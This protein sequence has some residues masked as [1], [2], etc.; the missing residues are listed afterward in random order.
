MI[1]IL[2]V[3]TPTNRDGYRISERGG[4]GVQVQGCQFSDFSLISDFFQNKGN[5]HKI[6]QIWSKHGQN[7]NSVQR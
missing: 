1:E 6:D 4:G 7:L 2:L 5:W 3:V